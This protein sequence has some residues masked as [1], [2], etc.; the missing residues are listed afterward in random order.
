MGTL[1]VWQ[2]SALYVGAVLGTGVIALPALATR[3]A[4]PASL[5]AW[6]GLVLLSV[7]LAATFAALGARYPDGGGVSTYVRH[8]FGARAAAVVGWCFY[9]AVPAG[10][11]AAGM[12]AGAYVA[13]ALGG[14]RRTVV[15]TA[16]VLLVL[17]AVA[18]GF[19]LTFSGR[20]QLAL[21]VLLV[22]LLLAAV[23]AALPHARLRN[24]HPFAPHGWSA[25]GSAAALL[26][27]SFAGW[28]AITHLAADFRRP[29][30]D[31]PRATAVAI[32]VVGVLYLAVAA[33][34]VLVLGPAAGTSDAPLAELLALGV[35]GT[36]QVLAAAVAVLLTLGTMNA[37]FAGAARLGGALGRDGALPAWLARG[38]SVG[39]VPRRSLA[40][41]SG[42][43]GLALAATAVAGVG[44][45]PLVLLTTGSF[46]T[47]YALGTA[48]A[49]RLLPRGSLSRRCALLALV[50]VAALLVMTGWYL[51]WPLVVTV[52]ALGYLRR[53]RATRAVPK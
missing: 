18:N 27:W 4:G 44:T 32:A 34:S 23:V 39:E 48:A 46:V 5:L 35:G 14:G 33:T 28:E 42:L 19:G 53:R 17:V 50:A 25:V 8:A 26:V 31:L 13:G 52:G 30:R 12:F 49:L 40:V 1:T 9:F 11:P 6:L 45:R 3:A 10:A 47:V 41:V 24:L 36:V 51:L 16:A 29:A 43:S 7:P 38:G 22:A 21:A 37:Y 15:V 20:L 2:G